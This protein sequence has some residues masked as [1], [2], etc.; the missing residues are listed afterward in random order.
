M[1]ILFFGGG[2]RGLE[3]GVW[4]RGGE[5]GKGGKKGKGRKKGGVECLRWYW[6]MP[7]VC[8]DPIGEVRFAGGKGRK[9]ERGGSDQAYKLEI[10]L[11][12]V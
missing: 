6:C 5:K 11:R 3:F 8:S 9:K 7:L 1:S 10:Y 4:K 12:I 2:G